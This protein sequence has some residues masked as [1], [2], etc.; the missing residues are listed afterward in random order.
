[1]QLT[2]EQYAACTIIAVLAEID[3]TQARDIMSLA[4]VTMNMVDMCQGN[5]KKPLNQVCVMHALAV[6]LG[7]TTGVP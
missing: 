5:V 6:D 7:V 2:H 1:M 4:A 3:T